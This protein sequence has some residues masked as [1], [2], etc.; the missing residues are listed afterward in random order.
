MTCFTTIDDLKKNV[1]SLSVSGKNIG[2]NSFAQLAAQMGKSGTEANA[3]NIK[4][5]I[6]DYAMEESCASNQ[7]IYSLKESMSSTTD[8]INDDDIK[9]V[10]KTGHLLSK[11]R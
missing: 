2:Q 1:S 4:A 11:P 5:V 3:S 10:K 6:A 8:E 7:I 9:K